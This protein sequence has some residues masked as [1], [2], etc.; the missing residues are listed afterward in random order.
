MRRTIGGFLLRLTRNPSLH[1]RVRYARL[2]PFVPRIESGQP[3]F[4]K[5]LLPARN[6]RRGR[7]ERGHDLAVRL[8]VPQRQYQPR[9]KN[10]T[11]R[12]RPRARPLVQLTP[13][14]V[15]HFQ[16]KPIPSHDYLTDQ[17]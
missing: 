17:L 4:F 11:R 2:A 16:H 13:L 8:S 10:V 14:F 9:P 6:R 5:S 7:L 15:T 1:L 3:F 12:Q